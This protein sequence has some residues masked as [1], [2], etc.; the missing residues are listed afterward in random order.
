M[1]RRSTSRSDP[2][3]IGGLHAKALIDNDNTWS[4]TC[5]G[6][7][8][9]RDRSVRVLLMTFDSF[10]EMLYHR[11]ADAHNPYHVGVH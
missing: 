10:T 6:H 9:G 8:H 7:R 4:S 5:S 2:A 3:A 11:G 1:D